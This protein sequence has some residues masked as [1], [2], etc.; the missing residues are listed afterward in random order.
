VRS[1]APPWSG[2]DWL[3]GGRGEPPGS[4]GKMSRLEE[5]ESS[6]AFVYRACVSPDGCEA[7][8]CLHVSP[9]IMR[10]VVFGEHVPLSN[11]PWSWGQGVRQGRKGGGQE[12]RAEY[13]TPPSLLTEAGPGDNVPRPS[14]VRLGLG[15]ATSETGVLPGLKE[16]SRKQDKT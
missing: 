10:Q 3:E 12:E 13:A 11:T 9:E 2:W 8:V 6:C 14:A 15:S 4:P 7:E 5:Q 1:S 16:L